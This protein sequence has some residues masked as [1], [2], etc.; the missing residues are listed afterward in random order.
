MTDYIYSICMFAPAA[1]VPQ[2]QAFGRSLIKS[3]DLGFEAELEKDGV[4]WRGFVT[5]GRA[6][7]AGL[8][9]A[10]VGMI[11]AALQPSAVDASGEAWSEASVS[12]LIG[13]M[14]MDV[15]GPGGLTGGAHFDAFAAAC[16]LRRKDA[17][18]P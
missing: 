9:A 8:V 4:N 12:A 1:L 11:F 5:P 7:Y 13:A 10:P 6:D 18:L 17:A 16:G 14:H 2:A 3:I 15:E